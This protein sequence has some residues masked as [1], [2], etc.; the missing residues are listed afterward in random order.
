MIYALKLLFPVL[1]VCALA[2]LFL[3]SAFKS[4][5]EPRQY[6]RAWHVVAAATVIAF[7]GTTNAIYAVAILVLA[8][9]AR[10]YL[11]GDMRANLAAFVLLIFVLP[12]LT[13]QVG[14]LGDINYLLSLSGPRLLALALLVG[15]ALSLLGDRRIRREPWVAPLDFA[16]LGYQ[17]IKIAL[18]TPG[19]AITT[20]FRSMVESGLDVLLPYYVM[21]RAIRKEPDL[22]FILSHGM[23]GLAFQAA[24]GFTEFFVHRD[25]YSELQWVYGYKWQLTMNLMRGDHLRVQGAT[26]QPIVFAFEMIF[27]L[28]L[29]TWLRGRDWK[30]WPVRGVFA[31]LACALLFTF[32]RGP[33]LGGLAFGGALLAVRKLSVKSFV[34]LLVALVVAAVLVKVTGVDTAVIAMMGSVFGSS[35]ADMSTI[36]YRNQL[37]DTALALLKQSPWLGVP[38]YAAQ[39]QDLRQGEGIIDLVNSYIAIALDA[40]VIG[41]V[42]YLLPYLLVLRRLLRVPGVSR[43]GLAGVGDPSAGWFAATLLAMSIAM[44]LT[45]FTTSV[46][47]TMPFML[48]LLIALPIARLSMKADEVDIPLEIKPPPGHGLH[49][50]AVILR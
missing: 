29:W 18:L 28:G 39:M 36:V 23:L 45:I 12:P 30:L 32:S 4:L 11:G 24:V 34:G 9:L 5:L 20:V 46:F 42:V 17:V 35:E 47:F 44:L 3:R 37:L 1:V 31:L 2:A 15:P 8:R 16:V 27:A 26:P 21:S 40:G 33:W 10:S 49:Q 48:I 19:S 50:R 6:S 13:W 38:N 14:G 7:L 41:L 43:R 25:L 22:R